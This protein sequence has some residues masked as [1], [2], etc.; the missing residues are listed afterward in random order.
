MTTVDENNVFNIAIDGNFDDCQNIVKQMFSDL[1]FSK[2]INMSGNNSINFWQ[3]LY[4]KSCILFL[5]I[6]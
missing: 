3:E 6:F 1:E 4:V 2:S 5:F